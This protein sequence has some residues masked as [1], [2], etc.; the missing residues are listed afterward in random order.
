MDFEIYSEHVLKPY[1]KKVKYNEDDIVTNPKKIPNCDKIMKKFKKIILTVLII[2]MFFGS[3]FNSLFYNSFENKTTTK[4]NENLLKSSSKVETSLILLDNPG[5][6]LSWNQTGTISAMLIVKEDQEPIPLE[7]LELYV[8]IDE[9]LILFSGGLTNELGVVNF[10]FFVELDNGDYP[11]EVKF[12]CNSVFTSTKAESYF[13]VIN[14][15]IK[16]YIYFNMYSCTDAGIVFDYTIGIDLWPT[17]IGGLEYAYI[18]L[19]AR[20]PNTYSIE[21]IRFR[22]DWQGKH[23]EYKSGLI[24]CT[25]AASG[26]IGL[27]Y[28]LQNGWTTIDVRIE[29]EAEMLLPVPWPPFVWIF[30]ESET[31]S[32]SFNLIDD[33]DDAPIFVDNSHDPSISI[34]YEGDYNINLT[35]KDQSGWDAYIQYGFINETCNVIYDDYIGGT[36]NTNLTTIT[37]SIPKTIW[38]LFP[39][40]TI[41]YRTKAIDRDMDRGGGNK[42]LSASS[43]TNWMDAGHI[44]KSFGGALEKVETWIYLDDKWQIWSISPNKP[45]P[46]NTFYL[47]DINF[48]TLS[49]VNP[50]NDI[51]TV[52]NALLSFSCPKFLSGPSAPSPIGII[53][54]DP[55]HEKER[56]SIVNNQPFNPSHFIMDGWSST[57]ITIEFALDYYIGI[58]SDNVFHFSKSYIYTIIRPPQPTVNFIGFSGPLFYKS[59]GKGSVIDAKFN[60][61]NNA[62]APIQV[63]QNYQFSND[64]GSELREKL[65]ISQQF[66]ADVLIKPDE[67]E[68]LSFKMNVP[69]GGTRY[70]WDASIII[71]KGIKYIL[72]IFG[73][74]LDVR[75]IQVLKT[76][77]ELSKTGLK[78]LALASGIIN[79]LLAVYNGIVLTIIAGVSRLADLQRN[80]DF[81]SEVTWKYIHNGG[82][83]DTAHNV[84][85]YGNIKP[86]IYT[87]NLVPSAEQEAFFWAGF[88]LKIALG[89]SYGIAAAIHFSAYAGG[90]LAP[91]IKA[92]AVIS[93]LVC[94]AMEFLSDW[95]W[96]EANDDVPLN[97]NYDETY[98]PE[99]SSLNI[100]DYNVGNEFEETIINLGNTTLRMTED[101]RALNETKSR[102]ESAIIAGDYNAVLM[103][104]EALMDYSGRVADDFKDLNNDLELLS[105][106]M[107]ENSPEIKE[108]IYKLESNFSQSGLSEEEISLLQSNGFNQTEIQSL[109]ATLVN[110]TKSNTFSSNITSL[111]SDFE[112]TL[113]TSSQIFNAEIIRLEDYSLEIM[114]ESIQIKTEILNEPITSADDET[115]QQLDQLKVDIEDSFLRGEWNNVVE[116]SELLIELARNVALETNNNSFLKEYVEYAKEYKTNAKQFL[117]LNLYHLKEISITDNETKTLN[118]IGHSEGAPTANYILETNCSWVT[119]IEQTVAIVQ[120]NRTPIQLIISTEN[121][122]TITLGIYYVELK[123]YLPQTNTIKFSLLTINVMDDDLTP[124]E[125]LVSPFDYSNFSWQAM[126]IDDDGEIDSEAT[127]IYKVI[128]QNSNIILQGEI[129]EES[130]LETIFIPFKEGTYTLLI[131]AS[132]NDNDREND[133]ELSY[134]EEVIEITIDEMYSYVDW[135]L[136]ELAEYIENHLN[137]RY[138]RCIIHKLSKAQEQLQE[139]LYL[140]E[141]GDI[142]CGIYHDLIAKICVRFSEI[143]TEILNR[144]NRIDDEIAEYIISTLHNIRNN[145]V[146]LMGA[147]ICEPLAYDIALIEVELLNLNDFIKE[148]IP[149]YTNKYLSSKVYCASKMLEIALFRISMGYSIE[150][151]LECTQWKLERVIWRIDWN[152]KKGRVSEDLANYLIEE[153][154]RII[155]AI[156]QVI[157]N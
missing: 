21:V 91:L 42:D 2:L 55:I 124:P 81:V 136:E 53:I 86:S 134:F 17:V 106:H 69:L 31:Y 84:L 3:T 150:Y 56:L 41:R 105:Y 72:K 98:V 58:D 116:K 123:L 153:I 142:T 10:T 152:L 54:S 157:I 77:E 87:L 146:I 114:N 28:L 100:S 82:S 102:K 40:T 149:C 145:I 51:I 125:I 130:S 13:T 129:L 59:G 151:I 73:A 85:G 45:P 122:S 127:A 48:F 23:G 96:W 113:N 64:V 119:P 18:E 118:V 108:S 131:E 140:I 156:E 12:E 83:D 70:F 74:A 38:G 61:K 44:F 155:E 104:N 7:H 49:I 57:N 79:T 65:T 120:Y 133:E 25:S 50:L 15:Y 60:I 78:N 36:G 71:L 115:L 92:A 88:G 67:S 143:K 76:V 27:G 9:E 39:G 16:P 126:I 132:N 138:R 46:Y 5:K 101:L 35:Y 103:Q 47:R 66:K 22:H 30:E 109:N 107:K 111:V 128:D 43:W 68:E 63:T 6:M 147:S 121:D 4:I 99:Y 29:A 90:P 52:S 95:F 89:V 75:L 141:K 137:Y 14:D 1:D 19:L 20:K 94:L 34:Q 117:K 144:L 62:R 26:S 148:E 32:N 33:D 154:T 11:Y 8:F 110:V 37:Y 97:D 135:Q 139:A 93:T 80:Y 24:T 112:T